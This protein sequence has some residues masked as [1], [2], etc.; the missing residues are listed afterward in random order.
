MPKDFTPV[1]ADTYGAFASKRTCHRYL[2]LP[3]GTLS[4]HGSEALWLNFLK[5]LYACFLFAR[6][7]TTRS[8][9][10]TSPVPLAWILRVRPEPTVGVT[11]RVTFCFGA[12]A[13]VRISNG[14]VAVP[15]FSWTSRTLTFSAYLPGLSSRR[16]AS[17]RIEALYVGGASLPGSKVRISVSLPPATTNRWMLATPSPPVSSP[18]TLMSSVE[19]GVL[20]TS[21]GDAVTVPVGAVVSAAIAVAAVKAARSRANRVARRSMGEGD[22]PP[23]RSA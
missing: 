15:V 3:S 17:Q 20:T 10:W 18:E 22:P 7:M 23:A 14:N 1:F 21:A 9:P 2:P 12:L 5:T 8:L 6:W 4:V 11:S 16:P 13:G 19:L